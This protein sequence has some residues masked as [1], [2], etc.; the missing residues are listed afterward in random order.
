MKHSKRRKMEIM[1]KEGGNTNFVLFTKQKK[2]PDIH[3]GVV[4]ETGESNSCLTGRMEISSN[5][6]GNGLHFFCGVC[7]YLTPS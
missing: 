3:E 6:T 4:K 7:Y 2:S 1:T 5:S